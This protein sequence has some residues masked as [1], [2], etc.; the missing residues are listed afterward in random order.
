MNRKPGLYLLGAFLLLGAVNAGAEAITGHPLLE[1]G[2]GTAE[3]SQ[4][5]PVGDTSAHSWTRP[6]IGEISTGYGVKNKR[7]WSF[8]YHTGID[9]AV[10]SG[11]PVKAAS[12]GTVIAS[13]DGGKYGNHI[14]IKH[15]GGIY[16]EYAHLSKI[17]VSKGATV[18]S[19]M[20]IGASGASGNAEGPH[21]H[22]EVRNGPD[23]GD[24]I[25]PAT[26]LAKH[27]IHL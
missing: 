2:S 4:E 17:Y 8:G 12:D 5:Q 14:T 13:G 11:T 9:F 18:T 25:N 16:T 23:F 15:S 19:G 20:P 21:L 10:P 22:F 24:D 27:G 26:F 3:A 1:G 6:S 7:L